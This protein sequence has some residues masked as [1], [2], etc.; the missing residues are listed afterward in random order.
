M[1]DIVENHPD[2]SRIYTVLVAHLNYLQ[3]EYAGLDVKGQFNSE[4]ANLFK[5]LE[6]NSN[7]FRGETLLPAILGCRLYYQTLYS[8]DIKPYTNQTSGIAEFKGEIT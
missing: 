5:C 8:H 7:Q 6:N 1:T 3:S 2:L 4:T